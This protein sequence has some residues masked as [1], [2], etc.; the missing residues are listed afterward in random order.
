[1]RGYYLRKISIFVVV[2]ALLIAIFG[3]LNVA[4]IAN[5][6]GEVYQVNNKTEAI[7]FL[8]KLKNY[9]YYADD[10]YIGTTEDIDMENHMHSTFSFSAIE[11]YPGESGVVNIYFNVAIVN[12]INHGGDNIV[13]NRHY[14]LFS[15]VEAR[16]I[17]VNYKVN[18]DFGDGS[19]TAPCSYYKYSAEEINMPNV[20]PPEGKKFLGWV[21]EGSG[22]YV[23]KISAT[24]WGVKNYVATYEDDAVTPEVPDG[25][26]NDPEPISYPIVYEN[27]LDASGVDTPTATYTTGEEITLG[28]I[29]KEGFIFGG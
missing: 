25:P 11:K 9:S 21:E 6:Y 7:D 18:F 4:L 8:S 24:T 27:T 26:E 2:F 3:F 20:T 29:E 5:A 10:I 23:T 19:G 28:S 17:S 15:N 16:S 13:G 1:M 12:L 14:G 22:E